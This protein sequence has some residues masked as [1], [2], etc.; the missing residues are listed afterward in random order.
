M[1][2]SIEMILSA[3]F[4]KYLDIQTFFIYLEYQGKEKMRQTTH[5]ENGKLYE[6]YS[7]ILTEFFD[8]L[9][10]WEQGAV[11]ETGVSPAQMHLLEVIGRRGELRMKE[12][13]EI[14]G[15]TTGTLTV[16]AHRLEEKAYVARSK[17]ERDRRSFFITLT[18]RG[19]EEYRRHEHLHFHLIEEMVHTLGENK[20]GDFFTALKQLRE[21][22]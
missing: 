3:K 4:L 6:E 12:L 14:L 17:D 1:D 20:A 10:S 2:V 9:N 22:M 21:I 16:M 5:P 13:A 7:R 15:V 8:R 11:S 19:E 18:K